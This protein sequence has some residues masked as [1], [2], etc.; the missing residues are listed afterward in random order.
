[1]LPHSIFELSQRICLLTL[2]I[3]QVLGLRGVILERLQEQILSAIGDEDDK[4]FR[5][6][7]LAVQK[8]ANERADSVPYQELSRP[9][10][11]PVPLKP[12]L[13]SI[14]KRSDAAHETL[15]VEQ[16][17]KSA[18]TV[19]QY[20]VIEEGTNQVFRKPF[21]GDDEQV[22]WEGSLVKASDVMDN[23]LKGRRGPRNSD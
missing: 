20:P 6:L 22:M 10:P 18:K 12:N 7:K 21:R 9:I 13:T 2:S 4:Q 14:P 5:I 17:A 16:A 15:N 19:V 8:L 11:V 3:R 23:L 1:M